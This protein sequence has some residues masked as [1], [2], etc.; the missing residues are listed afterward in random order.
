MKIRVLAMALFCSMVFGVQSAV[1]AATLVVDDLPQT[2]CPGA[3]F[4]SIQAAINAASPGDTILVC[5][6]TY[7]EN[8]VL[9]KDLTLKGA[10]AG[11][12]ARG[13]MTPESTITAAA[14]TLLTLMTGSALSTIDGFTFLGGTRAIE[15]ATG[16]ING[17][18]I[19]N[20]RIQ[21]FTNSGVFLNDNG[22]NITVDK[23][24]IDGTAKIGTGDLVHLDQDNF[25]GFWFTN[26]RVVNGLTATGFFVDG[27]RNVDK[28]TAGARP[29]Q[30]T[31][32]FIDRNQ[33]GVNLGRLAWGDG[34]ITGNTFSNNDFDGLQGG[35]KNSSISQNSF[36][37]NGRSGLALT[38]FGNTTD[39]ARGAQNNTIT[40][41]CF[42]RNG[43]TRA[44]EG[45]LFS[46]TQFPGTISTNVAHQNNI[47]GN[48]NGVRYLGV[49]TIDAELN[50]WGSATGPTHVNNP[51]GT[52]DT[53]V[54][55]GNGVDYTPW[56]TTGAGSTPCSG[57]PA[58]TVTLDPATAINEVDTTHCVTATVT[59]AVGV[60]QAGVT[61][62][63]TVTGSV[64][65]SGS[66]STDAD[67][68][69]MFCYMGPAL[70]GADLITAVADANDDGDA[71][72]GEPFDTATKT[73]VLP[74]TTPG[75]EITITNGG[76]II[77]NN[78]DRANFGGN[79]K[80]DEDSNV[81]GQ[82]QYQDHGPVDPF[83]LHGQPTVIV[84]D[85]SDST[86]ATIFGD[87]TIDGSGP[88]TFRID[89]QD[90]AEPGRGMDKYRMQVGT[91]D[92]GDQVLQG[93]NVQIR[94]Q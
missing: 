76:W 8:L 81:S 10:Q 54:D 20:N 56:R 46:A 73:W 11:V 26:N 68:E 21:G 12:D 62:F 36:N 59:N 89:V 82:E 90:L 13:R 94:K 39:P 29:P 33:T 74:M 86:R 69:A 72:A 66:D 24:D 28:S 64:M 23:N 7:V 58:T 70:P 45:I 51:G 52:G 87:A 93:G 53:V 22:I 78:G 2:D 60:P 17:I 25:D 38:S 47:V 84:C 16:P 31:G 14:G 55:D 50:W 40:Q 61:V 48:F 18:E 42:T 65:T 5:A 35:P 79:A 6:G 3:P 83:T 77:A 41:N 92:S 43:L 80:A 57:G 15:S 34:P 30:F 91:Y 27:T 1:E 85:A 32:N 63:F 9:N 37:A 75:C 49:E 88:Y 67:G 71:D 19:L 44:G 4:F